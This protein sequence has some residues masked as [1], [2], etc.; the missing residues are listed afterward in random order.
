LGSSLSFVSAQIS[1][2]NKVFQ[3]VLH[4]AGIV[5][6]ISELKDRTGSSM[7]A[8]KKLMMSKF[9]AGQEVARTLL[10]QS[11]KAGVTAGDFVKVR[12]SYKAEPGL[13]EE[14]VA[15]EKGGRASKAAKSSRSYQEGDC[16]KEK[17]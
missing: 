9:P 15:A 3:H 6:A 4:K 7:I 14:A 10:P 5:D 8:I 11:L 13:Q 1:Q 12:V 2:A 16:T 17:K